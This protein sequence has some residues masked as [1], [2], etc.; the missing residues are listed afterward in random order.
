[1]FRRKNLS[2]ILI[3]SYLFV[4]WLISW[5][6]FYA[7]G[8]ISRLFTEAG[9]MFILTLGCVCFVISLLILCKLMT[10]TRYELNTL[11]EK[12]KNVRDCYKYDQF[13]NPPDADMNN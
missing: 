1:M 10:N 2:L 8:N 11:I 3:S 6:T 7:V 13:L 9:Y 4:L 5:L 12:E